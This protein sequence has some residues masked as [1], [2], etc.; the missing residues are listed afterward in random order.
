[1]LIRVSCRR[2]V[3]LTLCLLTAPATAQ[4]DAAR[5]NYSTTMVA[6]QTVIEPGALSLSQMIALAQRDNKA[7]QAARYAVEIG[8]GRLVQAGLLSNSRLEI[9]GRSDAVFSHEGEYAASI[10]ISQQFPVA[11]RVLR[12]KQ[13][14]RVDVAL[15]QA[16]VQEAERRMATEVATATYRVLILDRQI[17]ARDKLIVV[18]N[19]LAKTTRNRYQAAEVSELDVNTVKLDLQRL[20]QER[21]LLQTQRQLLLIA[22]NTL[23]GRDAAAPLAINEAIAE[24][25]TL[26]GLAQLQAMALN[27][28]P[29][30]HS[31]L[32][33]IDRAQAEQNLARAQRWE[34]WTVGVALSQDKLIVDGA[35]PQRISRAI[36]FNVSIPLLLFNKNQGAIAAAV[37]SSSQATARA[38]ALRLGIASEVASA[39]AETTSLQQQLVQ[40]PHTLFPVS[41][42]SVKLAQKGYGQGLVSLLEVIQ[43]QRQQSDLNAAYLTTLDQFLQ[44]LVRL[45]TATGEYLVASLPADSDS[46][47]KDN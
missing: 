45:R 24:S 34:D 42:R 10:G 31:A 1:M 40:Y 26:P 39:Y 11:G 30:L 15:A 7:L 3:V 35:P 27:T 20:A 18:E 46:A 38:A 28:R 14:A 5:A 32:L 17:Q 25:E 12:Q 13:L 33:G 8:R 16:E 23:L 6:S 2:G 44:A 21:A 4:A 37:A 22:L 36:G 29:D 47:Q 9:S 19:Q 41:Q 43:A